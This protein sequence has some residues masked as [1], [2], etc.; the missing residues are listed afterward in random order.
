MVAYSFQ[1]RFVGAIRSGAK[2]QTI[3]APRAHHARPGKWLQL[4]TG[5]RTKHCVKII[6]DPLCVRLSAVRL[7][8]AD[9][10]LADLVAGGRCLRPEEFDDFARRD[11]F[12]DAADMAGFWVTQHCPP[13][14]RGLIFNGW[15]IEW[16]PQGEVL[17]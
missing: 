14:Q 17:P 9:G 4:F 2:R 3:R 12:A 8:I 10:C 5:M 7:V 13:G 15:L 1:K 6:P 11:G 16:V